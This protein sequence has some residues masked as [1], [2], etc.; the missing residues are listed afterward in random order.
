[1]TEG[2]HSEGEGNQDFFLQMNSGVKVTKRMKLFQVRKTISALFGNASNAALMV[3]PQFKEPLYN[4][5][6]GIT[7]YIPHPSN[8]KMYGKE[9][10]HNETLL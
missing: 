1:M 8:S 5:V 3:E 2:N 7:N 4:K 9:P 10:R 6:L